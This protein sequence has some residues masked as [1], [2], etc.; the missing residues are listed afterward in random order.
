MS[1][2]PN[3][4]IFLGHV[5]SHQGVA[6]DP[7]TEAA[8]RD[9][10]TPKSVHE[11]RAFVG[12]TSYYRRFISGYADIAKPLHRMTEKNNMF[13]WTS[14]C[15]SAFDTLKQK[16]ITPKALAYPDPSKNI[17]AGY[18][19]QWNC[20]WCPSIPHPRRSRAPCCVLYPNPVTCRTELLCHPTWASC[21]GR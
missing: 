19:L 3:S 2:L 10:P 7:E 17:S 11:V 12:T 16:L 13:R 20:D 4:V 21:R 1:L 8:I 18:R 5:V 14:E 6:T 15:Q 9:W